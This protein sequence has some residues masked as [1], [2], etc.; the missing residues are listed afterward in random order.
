MT[1]LKNNKV[2]FAVVRE[3]PEI[4]S[5]IIRKNLNKINKI[6][7]IGSGGCTALTIRNEFPLIKQYLIEPN[8]A[9]IDLIKAKELLIAKRDLDKLIQLNHTG[10]FESLFRQLRYFIYEFIISEDHLKRIILNNDMN[11]ISYILNHKYWPVGFELYFS[12]VVLN[13][14]FGPSA[15]QHAEKKSYPAYFRKVFEYGLCRND[16]ST[17]YFLHHLLFSSY[18][19][20]HLPPYLVTN[21][22]ENFSEFD[23]INLS[24]EQ[25][26]SFSNFDF[27]SFSNIFDWS[28]TDYIQQLATKI[29]NES[30][31]GSIIIFRQLN[32]P[33][34]F[35]KVFTPDFKF[36]EKMETELLSK[37]RSLFYSQLNIGIKI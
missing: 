28:S 26:T 33:Q 17:N 23:Y 3:D 6:L 32:N 35:K 25:I 19:L 27:M 18:D 11:S 15:T 10:N 37:D 36:N 24:V 4:E 5:I 1:T 13:T 21:T 34:D 12:D 2:Q 31:P 14:M 22:P 29:K 20:N 16:C 30:K 7:L 8:L 9:Q